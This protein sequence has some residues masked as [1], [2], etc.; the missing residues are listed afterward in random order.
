MESEM[1]TIE[2]TTGH[3]LGGEGN[4]VYPGTVMVAPRDLSLEA[5]LAKVRRGYARVIPN[6]IE[7]SDPLIET[8]DPAPENRDPV[9]N[10][11]AG[12]LP[13]APRGRSHTGRR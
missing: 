11:P 2:I 1:L 3:C 8:G 6:E 10:A 13:P 4:D 12:E 5:A 9:V 7:T